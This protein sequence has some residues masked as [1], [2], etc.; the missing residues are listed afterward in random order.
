[1]KFLSRN[2][3]RDIRESQPNYI[4]L[5]PPRRRRYLPW[6]WVQTNGNS[7]MLAKIIRFYDLETGN[8]ISGMYLA[9][10]INIRYGRIEAAPAFKYRGKPRRLF[11]RNARIRYPYSLARSCSFVP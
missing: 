9:G 10:A 4:Y 8:R 6:R 1:M 11:T 2:R 5:L 3:I 7:A